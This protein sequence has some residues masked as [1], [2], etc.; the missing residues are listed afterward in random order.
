MQLIDER[1]QVR[2]SEDNRGNKSKKAVL[3]KGF[4]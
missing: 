1:S 4:A 2:G 3:G